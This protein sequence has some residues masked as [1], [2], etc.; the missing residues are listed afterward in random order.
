MKFNFIRQAVIPRLCPTAL[1]VLMLAFSACA[2]PLKEKQQRQSFSMRSSAWEALQNNLPSNEDISWFDVQAVGPDA[3]RWRLAL[4][5]TATTSIDAQYFIWKED[6]VGSLLLDRLLQAADRGVRVRMLIDDSFLAGEDQLALA[7]D[8]HPHLELRIFNPFETRSENMLLR[9]VENLNDYERINHRMHNKLLISDGQVAVVGGRNIAE[10]YFGFNAELNFRDFD[11]MVTG[12][13]VPDISSSF[14]LYWNSGWAYPVAEV[15]H[16]KGAADELHRLQMELKTRAVSLSGWLGPRDSAPRDWS[17]DWR[18]LAPTLLSGRAILLQD[19]PH[20]EGE[21]PPV[22]AAQ[23]I[24]AQFSEVQQEVMSVSAYLIPS[25]A[26]IRIAGELSDRGVEIKALTNSLATN[27]HVPAHSAYRHHRKELLL[28]GVDLYEFK[29]DAPERSQF[30]APGFEADH[31]GLHAK[32]LVL[33]RQRLFIGTMNADPRSMVLNTE[34]SLMI[35]S[36]ELAEAVI[37]VFSSDFQPQNSWRVMLDD[38]G[39]MSWQS[40]EGVL[41]RQPSS[42]AWHRV[43]DFLYGV[44]PIDDQ[45]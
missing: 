42:S 13:V 33:D 27:N 20:F 24:V 14:D 7:A 38:N 44:L 21:S 37:S 45:M 30:E 18:D 16:K 15:D 26:M 3:L 17:D 36:P 25:A 10:E 32:I 4:I 5:D 43:S 11:L 19:D 9:Y 12:K 6:A 8:A 41:D 2:T 39:A 31:I 29:P 1:I 40:S 34:V 35:D 22:Q 23:Q 28:A